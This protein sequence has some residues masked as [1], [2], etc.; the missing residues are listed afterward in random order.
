MIKNRTI[1][2]TDNLHILRDMDS[3]C[4]DLIYLDPPFNSKRTYEAL[5]G[6]EVAGASFKDAWTLADT[7][8][9]WWGRLPISALRSIR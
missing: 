1:F 9:A 2:T 6:G 3:E 7:D 8:E 5:I 4:A